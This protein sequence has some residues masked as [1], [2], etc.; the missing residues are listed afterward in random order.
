MIY[1]NPAFTETFGWTLEELRGRKIPFVPP[2]RRDELSQIYKRL[3]RE[4]IILRQE[5]R[6]LTKN[7]HILDV[8]MR[9]AFFKNNQGE[10]EGILVFL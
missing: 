7:G 4:K 6:R 5:S 3:L 10:P 2:D 8:V 1:L 9:A